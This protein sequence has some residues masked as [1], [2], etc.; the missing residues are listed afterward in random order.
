MINRVKKF[1]PK[2]RP[3]AFIQRGTAGIRSLLIDSEGKFVSDTMLVKEDYSLHLL[4]Y[5]SPGATGAL[6]VGA[7]ITDYLLRSGIIKNNRLKKEKENK[8]LWDIRKISN[9]MKLNEMK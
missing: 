3:S 8:S 7:A 4:N 2:L 1:L 9:E 6:P 5:N